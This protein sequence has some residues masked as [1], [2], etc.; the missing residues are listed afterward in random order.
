MKEA[1]AYRF[2][3]GLVAVYFLLQLAGLFTTGL[4][5]DDDFYLPAGT[6]YIA[7]VGR[8][9]TFDG[10]AFQ[11]SA[12]DASFGPN[13]EHPPV[14]KYALGLCG[15]LFGFLGPIDGPRVATVFWSTLCA[16]LL[17]WLAI[18]HLG[19]ERGR[20]VGGLGALLLLFLPRFYF[21]SHVG[22]LDVPV[23]ATYLLGAAVALGAERSRRLAWLAGPAFGIA[24]A[25]KLNGPFLI[26]PMLVF[27]LLTRRPQTLRDPPRQPVLGLPSLPGAFWSMVFVGPVVFFALWPWLWV[28][29][30][31][32]TLEYVRF[33]LNH[34]PIFL[35]YFGTVFERPFAPWHAPFV[36]TGLTVPGPTL[37]LTMVGVAFG[38]PV[39]LRRIRRGP[40][41]D[42]PERREGDLLLFCL[43]HAAF[44]IGVVAFSGAPKYGGVKL[45][46]P[47]FPFAC[48]L[49]G[50]GALRLRELGADAAVSLRRALY[51]V[52][53]TA[54][55]ASAVVL[56]R[57]GEYGLSQ[58]NLFAGGLRGATVLGMERQYYDVPYREM[59]AWL[60]AEA[61]PRAKV[62]FLPNNWEYERTFRWYR[63]AGV[64]REDISVA[65][66]E[67]QA[68]LVVLTHERR[69]RR[70]STDLR[71]Y[72]NRE[73]LHTKRLDGVPLW[74]VLTGSRSAQP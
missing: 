70:Y 14:A 56:L 10:S 47:F 69:F 35:F 55:G 28:D 63:K 23:A 6:S 32:R 13:H 58:Y 5:D 31:A 20:V 51:W 26:L 7:W 45:F 43:L 65:K 33:H 29:P 1:R 52:G 40:V 61:P 41:E 22:T 34:Y 53:P 60:N 72:R 38:L 64:L 12:I 11:A 50:Y 2:T 46:L 57:Y 17:L 74:T 15:M 27:W 18:R 66:S 3:A 39:A 24:A 49:A 37:L 54:V 36:M 16:A 62:H 25:T 68:H 73:V 67:R 21:H 71:R 48:L 30:V 4:T 59:I 8:V 19:S 9:L 42:D 44:T